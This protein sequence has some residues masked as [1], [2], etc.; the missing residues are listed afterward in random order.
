MKVAFVFFNNYRPGEHPQAL[1]DRLFTIR[2]WAGALASQRLEVTVCLRFHRAEGVWREGVRYYFLPAHPPEFSGNRR[3]PLPYLWQ[4]RQILRE[5]APDIVHAHDLNTVTANALLRLLTPWRIPM[6]LQDHGALPQK[7]LWWMQRLIFRTMDGFLFS[8]PG[9]EDAWVT[10]G[11]IPDRQRCFFVMENSAHFQMRPR[12]EARQQTALRGDPVFLWVGHLNSNKDPL[13]VLKAFEQ[14]LAFLPRARLYMIY[15]EAPLEAAVRERIAAGPVL[16]QCVSLLGEK[17]RR[18]MEAYYNSADYL[19]SGSHKEGSGYALIEAMACG[20][21]PIVTN[22]P[23]FRHLTGDGAI[24]ALWA[25]D[26]AEELVA[27]IRKATQ[28]PIEE[29]ARAVREYFDRWFG[30]GAL[31]KR[32]ERVYRSII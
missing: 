23:S 19:L 13:T 30:F 32:M 17:D 7:R 24:G 12:R 6:L 20:V 27:A 8:A 16:P 9:Q 2:D 1:L 3:I 14:V 26:R 15:R 21:I 10:Q 4:V 28:W 25:P 29:R 11:L 22:I 5:V 31:A 18:A